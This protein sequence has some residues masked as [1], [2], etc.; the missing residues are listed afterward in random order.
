MVPLLTLIRVMD[1]QFGETVY[2]SEVNGATT[3]KSDAQV[4][5]NNN[6]D[7]MQNFYR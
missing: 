7:S 2:I 5:K 3:V 6:S 4:A 1:P